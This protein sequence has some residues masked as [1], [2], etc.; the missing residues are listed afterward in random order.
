VPLAAAVLGHL[1]GDR[2]VRVSGFA[3]SEIMVVKGLGYVVFFAAF[4]PLIFGGKISTMLERLMTFKLVVVLGFLVFVGLFMVPARDA[5]EIVSGFFRVG[6]VAL[7]AETVIAAPHFSLLERDQT[8]EYT[9]QGTLEDDRPIVTALVVRRGDAKERFDMGARLPEGGAL[10]I[11]RAKMAERAAAIVRRGGFYVRSDDPATGARVSVEGQIRP[12][13][14]W[15]ADRVSVVLGTLEQDYSRIED[16][17]APYC[18]LVRS[19]VANQGF[20]RVGLWGYCRRHGH[21][22]DL[23]WSLLAAFAA[24]AGAGGLSNA[25]FSNYARD[26]GW[27][28]GARAGAI[29]SAIGGRSIELSHN[30][31]AFPVTPA[32]LERWRG[33]FRHIVRD[34]VAVWMVCCFV[35]LALP[36]MLSLQFL[37]N[38]PVSDHRVAAM[39]AEGMSDRFPEFA[40]AVWSLTLFI[41][42]L[43]LAPCAVHS[44]DLLARHWTDILWATS[45]AVK[46]LGGNHVKFLYYALLGVYAVWGSITLAIMSPLQIAKVGAV[47]CNV[48]LGFSAFHTLYVNRTLLPHELRPNTLMQLGLLGCGLFF[49]AITAMVLLGP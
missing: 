15:Q 39:V 35:G 38:T 9:V 7:R 49:F 31:V 42:F 36:C 10:E 32:N 23:D 13:R 41:S 1:P 48:A 26:K 40:R 6:E 29:P 43:T 46:N 24:I 5:Y 34:Q 47:L 12:G 18:E 8:G 44:A 17:P 27:G 4:V 37:R 2:L 30:G 19:W 11:R 16:V 28:M 25:L 22:P 3:A 45:P 33:W 14:D 20:E 21:L